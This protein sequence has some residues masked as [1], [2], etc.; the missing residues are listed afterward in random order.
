[1]RIYVKSHESR[2]PIIIW[3]PTSL[4]AN[5]FAAKTA[6]K[7]MPPELGYTEEK[8]YALLRIMKQYKG[9]D[10][11]E[12]DSADGDRVRIRL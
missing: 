11:V 1:M 5:R 8:L 6:A 2:L 12:V 4:I 10:I 3:M 7:H 9:L